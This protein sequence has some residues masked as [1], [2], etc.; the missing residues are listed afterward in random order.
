MTR[1][2]PGDIRLLAFPFS[3]EPAVK[4]RP[5]VVVLDTGDADVLVARITTQAC[6]TRYDV[7]VAAWQ[8]AGL[9]APSY[10]RSHKLAVI[11][12]RLVKR[13]LG[14]LQQA[15]W[16]SFRKTFQQIYCGDRG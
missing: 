5:A 15:D 7:V 16:K 6:G 10:V 13:K 8:L 11:E 9:L 14:A 12:K 1:F 2:E 3:G 4:Q